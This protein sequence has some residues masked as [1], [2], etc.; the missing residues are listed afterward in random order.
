MRA[1]ANGT[2]GR[3]QMNEI[4]HGL[5]LSHGAVAI[6]GLLAFWVPVFAKKGGSVHRAAGKLFLLSMLLVTLTGVPLA[7]LLLVNGQWVFAVFLLYL[8][9]LLAASTASAWAAIKL[10]GEPE[11][12]FGR[13]HLAVAWLIFASGAG[14]SLLGYFFNEMLLVM[15]GCIGPFV[16]F[17]MFKRR[18]AA[19]AANWWL[20]EHFGGMIGGGIATH[21]AFAAFGLRRLWPAYAS[22][23]GWIGILPWVAPVVI[24]VIAT[25]ILEN[26]YTR[27]PVMQRPVAPV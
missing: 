4:Y 3:L 9:V 6:I 20:L 7:L 23:D 22:L 26:C 8:A 11:R 12:Y 25:V 14:V 24:G 18:R 27:K 5:V 21:V 2:K 13:I 10:K 17:D 15:F 19:R 16:A 1:C